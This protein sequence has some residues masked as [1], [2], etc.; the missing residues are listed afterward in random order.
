MSLEEIE[1]TTDE[2]SFTAELELPEGDSDHGAVLL[3]GAGHTAFD[4]AVFDRLAAA[5]ADNGVQ[6][7]RY[8]TWDDGEELAEKSPDELHAEVDAALEHLRD[9]GCS[10]ITLVGKSA[11]G[12]IAL[13]SAPDRIDE[14]VLWAPAL[15]LEG[16]DVLADLDIREDAEPPTITAAELA[17]IDVPVDILQGDEDHFPV[18]SARELADEIPDASV[19]VIEGADHSFIGGDPETETIETTLELLSQPVGER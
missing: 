8:Q 2:S 18:A 1:L 4:D 5:A 3:S 19:H 13:Q 11:G 12:V 7:L 16:G 10:R 15:F 17:D 14:M 6:F 9:R